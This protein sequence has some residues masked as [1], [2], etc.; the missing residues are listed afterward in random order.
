MPTIDEII[1]LNRS[2]CV[3]FDSYFSDSCDKVKELHSA[4]NKDINELNIE[5]VINEVWPLARNKWQQVTTVIQNG[6]IK[7]VELDQM[8]TAYFKENY[9]KMQTELIYMNGYF[10]IQNLNLRNEQIK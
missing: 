6:K 8:L 5:H 4:K 9:S 1:N 7:L 2:C 3:I 10:K